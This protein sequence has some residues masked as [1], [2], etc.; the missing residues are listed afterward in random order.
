MNEQADNLTLY[1]WRKIDGPSMPS[2]GPGPAG[3]AGYKT[4]IFEMH[5]VPEGLL[6]CLE[7]IHQGKSYSERYFAGLISIQAVSTFRLKR[8]IDQFST[9]FGRKAKAAYLG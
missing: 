8:L 9:F 7:R 6:H 2:P 4:T 3:E 5:T 1:L